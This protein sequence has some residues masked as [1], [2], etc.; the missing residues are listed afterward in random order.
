MDNSISKFN[1]NDSS[2]IDINANSNNSL[3]PSILGTS[4]SLS[5]Q[6]PISQYERNL[7]NAIQPLAATASTVDERGIFRVDAAGKLTIDFLA[8][9]G[10]YH[11]QMAIFSL[12][13]MENLAVG[14]TDFV[15][16]AINRA[17]SSSNLGYVVINDDGEGARFSG[18]LGES[19]KNDGKYSGIK[20]FNFNP[21]DRVAMMIVP[22]G[23][24]RGISNS[25]FLVDNQ[26][27]LFSIASANPNKAVQLGQLLPNT[28]GWEDLRLDKGGDADYNDIVFQVKGLTG[29]VVD[30]SKVV[31]P[32]KDWQ[33]TIL[34]KEIFYAVFQDDNLPDLKGSLSTDTG[35]S[36]SD[37]ITTNPEILGNLNDDG[38][39]RRFRA[40]LNGGESIDVLSLLQPDNSFV[41]GRQELSLIKGSDLADGNY[42]LVL[43]AEDKFGKVSRSNVE[44]VLDTKAA[45]VPTEVKLKNSSGN[46]T[47]LKTPTLTGKAEAGTLVQVFDGI[48]KLG[49]ILAVDGTWEV[50]TS[51]LTAGVK[52]LTIKAIDLAGNISVSTP[53]SFTIIN[54]II[55]PA[56][57]TNIKIKDDGDTITNLQTPTLVGK[58]ETGNTVQIFDGLTKLGE[59]I[60]A[61]GL[62]AITTSQL[63]N[64]LKNLIVKSID[65]N[66]NV[67]D[68]TAF[69]LTVDSI[70]P[71]APTEI[72]IKD[73]TDTVTALK[74]PTLIGKAEAGTVVQVFDG[75]TKIGEATVVNGAWEITTSS[76]TDGVK[77]LT[78]K[79]IDLAGNASD[80]TAFSLTVDSIK[81]VAPTEVKIKDDTDAV[82]ALKTPTLIGKAETGTVVQVFDGTTK[83]GEAT[84]VNGAWEITTSSLT[85]GVKNLTVKSIDVAGNISDDTAF[86][87]TVDTKIPK[88]AAP[89]ELKIKNDLDTITSLKVPTLTGK[90]ENGTTVQVFDGT[91]KIGEATVVN[92]AWEITTSPLTDGV[93]NL[94]VKSI[95]SKGN[96]SDNTAFSLT[97]DTLLPTVSLT[98]PGANGQLVAGSRL[99][100]SVDGTGSAISAVSYR[101]GAGAEI[102]VPI[103]AGQFDVALNLAGLSGAQ[104]LILR[105]VDVAGNTTEATI[106]VTVAVVKDTTPPKVVVASRPSTAVNFVELTFDEPVTDESFAADKYS[107]KIS[108]GVQDGQVVPIGSVQKLSPTQVRVNLATA[109]ATGSY[110]LALAAG[111]TDV[112]GNATTAAQSFDLIVASAAVKISPASGEEKVN[113]NRDTIV[114]FGKK[115]DPATVT[116]DNFYLIANGQRVAGKIKVSSTEEFA[117]FIYD[118]SLPSSTEIRVTVNGD[119]IIGRDGLAIDGNGDGTPGGMA[120]GDFSTLPITQIPGTEVYG[121]VYDSYNKN[122]DGSNI[123]LKGVTIRLDSLPNVTATTDEKGYFILKDLPA[124]DFFVYI[125]GAKASGLPTVSSY[126]GLGKAFHSVPGQSVQLNANGTA[127]NIYLPPMAASDVQ[128]LSATADTNVGFGAAAQKFLQDTFPTIDPELWKDVKVTFNAGSAQDK[129]GVKATQ[130]TIIPVAPDRLP[131]PLPSGVD[132]KL[133]ISIQAGGANGFNREVQGGSTTFDVPAPIQFPNLEGLKPGEKSLFW[134]FDHDAGKWVVIGTGTVSADGRMVVSDP[135]VGVLS[136]GWHFAS[137]GTT[138]GG[139]KTFLK[140][141]G[142]GPKY[143]PKPPVKQGDLSAGNGDLD[144]NA[145][146]PDKDDDDKFDEIEIQLTTFIPSEI[147]AITDLAAIKY[148]ATGGAIGGAVA[149]A[150]IGA[151]TIGALGAFFGALAGPA[152]AVDVG[153]LGG[154]IG[155]IGGATVGV[156][157]GATVGAIVGYIAAQP[158]YNG[159]NRGFKYVS[160]KSEDYKGFS[161]IEIDLNSPNHPKIL[162]DWSQSKQY[163]RGDAQPVVGKLPWWW[164]L[165]TPGIQPVYAPP[166]LEVNDNNLKV[167]ALRPSLSRDSIVQDINFHVSGE[168]KAFQQPVIDQI[169][170]AAKIDANLTVSISQTKGSKPQY[171]ISGTHDGFPAYELYIN[172]KLVYSYLPNTDDGPF[173][174]GLP[175]GKSNV[176]I[177]LNEQKVSVTRRNID[178]PATIQP[179][180]LFVT[181]V[182]QSEL[183]SSDLSLNLENTNQL[184]SSLIQDRIIYA[185]V[186]S[187]SGEVRQRG[188]STNGNIPN[189]IVLASNSLNELLV[190][191]PKTNAFGFAAILTGDNGTNLKLDNQ[192]ILDNLDRVDSDGDGLGDGAELVLG[193]NSTQID[194]DK[195]GISDFT[196]FEQGLDPLGDRGFPTGIISSLPLQGEAKAIVIEGST[197]N[198]TQTAYVATGS[199][200][201]AVVNTSQFNEPIILGQLNLAGDATDVAV[202]T[203]LNIAAVAANSGGLHLVNVAD[204]MLPTLRQSVNINSSQVEIADGIAYATVNN[205]LHSIDLS[206][207]QELQSLTLIGIGSVTGLV[208]EG[209]KLYAFTNGSNTFSIIDIS[210]EGSAQLLGQLNV[211]NLGNVGLSVGNGVA[212]LSS[213]GLTTIDV[214]DPTK[215][216]LISGV[217]TRF[218]S[219]NVTLNG[220]GLAL[221]TGGQGLELYSTVD[222][223]KTDNFVTRINTPSVA[224]GTAIAS[225][226]AY[227]A[228]GTSGL[229]IINYLPF[230]NKGIAPIINL[231]S[232]VTDLDPNVDGIQVQEGS[233]IPLQI[234]IT[235]DVQ[236]RNVELLVDG[237]VVSNDVSFPWDLSVV[238]PAIAPGKDTVGIQVRA[239]DTGGNIALSNLLT[240]NL[241]TDKFAPTVIG[242]TPTA[243][244]RSKVIPTVAIK[245]NEAIDPT[246][247]NVSGITLTNLGADG[248]LGGG[249][250]VIATVSSLQTRNFDKTLVIQPAGE[251]SVGNYQLSVDP[252]II[253][254]RVGNVIAAPITTSFTKRPLTTNVTI[255]E[256]IVGKLVQP[257]DDE[258]YTFNGTAGQRLILDDKLL[259]SN[260][261]A[262]LTNPSGRLLNSDGPIFTASP[263]LTLTE[264]GKYKFT[265]KSSSNANA[266]GDYYF[267][268]LDANTAP[269]ITLGVT[270]TE[271]LSAGLDTNVYRIDGV[272]GQKL[273]FNSSVPSINGA[274]WQLYGTA[275]QQLTQNFFVNDFEAVLPNDGTY[276]LALSRKANNPT[277]INYS[278]TVTSPPVTTA[279]LTLGTTITD[280][281]TQPGETKEYTFV[282]TAGQ[283]LY[284][285]GLISNNSSSISSQLINP[286]G[287]DIFQDIFS[288]SDADRDRGLLTLTESGTY[289]LV[290][291]G[292]LDNVGD[293]SFKLIDANVSPVITLGET[294]T[295]VLAPGLET[296]IY[297]I[298]GTA[299]QQ[300]YIDSLLNN[301]NGSWALYGQNNQFV[302][303][304]NGLNNDFEPVLPTDGTYLLVINGQNTNGNSNYSFKVTSPVTTTNALNLGTTVTGT[305]SKVGEKNIYTFT[306]LPGQKLFYD[307]VGSNVNTAIY[308]QLISPNGNIVFDNKSSDRDQSAFTLT[309]AGT[310]QIIID[311]LG[312]TIGDYSFRLLDISTATPLELGTT[313]TSTLT[314]GLKS[315]FYQIRGIAGQ[316]LYFDS[317]VNG[318]N[319]SWSLY[320][321]NDQYVSGASLNNDFEAILTDTGNYLLQINGQNANGNVNYS[322]KV[323][324]VTATSTVLTLGDTVASKIS[325]AGEQDIYTFTGTAGQRIYYDALTNTTALITA[326]LFS[327]SG[328]IF[329]AGSQSI[330]DNIDAD[331]DRRPITLTESGT[332][333]LVLDGSADSTGDYSFRLVDVS[334]AAILSLNTPTSGTLNP[335][336]KTEVYQ[337]NG[338]AGQKL[339]FDSLLTGAVNGSWALYNSNNQYLI[340]TGLASDFNT[341]LPNDGTY[342]LL[343][344]GSSIFGGNSNGTVNYN[345][346]VTDVSDVPVSK[347]GFNILYTGTITTGGQDTYTLA[348]N[349]GTFVYFDSQ[350]PGANGLVVEVKDAN[351]QSVTSF[352]ANTDTQPLRLNTS[353]NHTV[354]VKGASPTSIGSYSFQ[355]IDITTAATDLTL[356]TPVTKVLANGAETVVYKFSGAAG[357]NLYY[358]GLQND[359]DMVGTRLITPSGTILLNTNSDFDTNLTTLT[360]SGTYYLLISGN[361]STA[362][363]YSFNLIDATAA[364]TLTLDAVVTDKLEPGLETNIYRFSGVAGQRLYFNSLMTAANASWTLYGGTNNQLL[365]IELLNSDFET[366]LTN[367]GNYFLVLRGSNATGNIDYSF[368]VTNLASNITALTLGATITDTITQPG[369][370]K[371]YT[372]AGTAGQILYYDGLINNTSIINSRLFS[373]SGKSAFPNSSFFSNLDADSDQAPFVLTESGNYKLTIDGNLD[374][375]GDFSFKL[376]DTS[377]APLITFDQIVSESLTPSLEADIYRINVTAEEILYFDSLL[378]TTNAFWSLYRLDSR[379]NNGGFGFGGNVLSTDF[380]T[381]LTTSGTYLLVINGQN[382]TDNIKYSFKVT[383]PTS[384]TTAVTLGTTVTGTI[385]QPG[386]KDIYTFTGTTGQQLL[387]DELVSNRNSDITAQLISPSGQNIVYN[388]NNSDVDLPFTLTESGNYQII[389]DGRAADIGD[390]AFRLIDLSTAPPVTIGTTIT[391]TLTPGLESD[392]YQI[393]AKAGERLYFDSLQKSTGAIWTLYKPNGQV[394]NVVDL[395]SDLETTTLDANGT[396]YLVIRG[397]TANGNVNYSFKV[398]N[399]PTSSTPLTLGTTI[400][401]TI[402]EVGEVDEYTFTAAVGQQLYYDGLGGTATGINSQIIGPS[403][404]APIFNGAVES[405]RRPVTITETGVYRLI[406]DGSGGNIG[407][408]NFRLLNTS[409]APVI[410]LNTTITNTLDPGLKT[411][412]Y[413]ISGKAGQKL[414]F[415]SLVTGSVIG[416]WS[417][418]NSNYGYINGNSFNLS[419]D[420]EVTLN[421]DGIYLLFINGDNPNGTVNYKFRVIE[422]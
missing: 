54:E 24:I 68:D 125:D 236:V 274:S 56:A 97:V 95:D 360:E 224:Y 382:R 336:L 190:W 245:F 305:I 208:R 151:T 63:I 115:V 390:Y 327:P 37:R 114:N 210:T 380:E 387:Y 341:T 50:T 334:T 112:A 29:S 291:D 55:K 9:S 278:F 120:T 138:F 140:G 14:S 308:A 297:R 152:G 159:N 372:F 378:N 227:V 420:F 93:K 77:N 332:Y 260:F 417:L 371:E 273:L 320:G 174:L 304:G 225:G 256:S 126:A 87:L 223:Q 71:V 384:V 181:E 374:S 315:D 146:T 80:D 299:G 89:T 357:Q 7:I 226:I 349:A 203:N 76:L 340:G 60:V 293:Y 92:G 136:P 330:F 82:T 88:P 170:Q 13:G 409:N 191:Q 379:S 44:F 188:I 414:R 243:D 108:G 217:D 72:K 129:E 218:P 164:E 133:V 381:T 262:D 143:Q 211:G 214:S 404:Q 158:V 247:L 127:F 396:Y 51:E 307:A 122:A 250:D 186:D 335:G 362:A 52:D 406:I 106:A 415:D 205:V 48:K 18:E 290:I 172:K 312:S 144:Q 131:A 359:A 365:A 269:A 32:G 348:A 17:L 201:L 196:E 311:G 394:S 70:K 154:A 249:D 116:G 233:T 321:L 207:G 198:N 30:V 367:N 209:T 416:K 42:K 204:G 313:V 368:N 96:A 285:D 64:G 5:Q 185:I 292:Q 81:P 339:K 322:F 101:F 246:K 282:G 258:V 252:S 135:G 183:A 418:Y 179:N 103:T 22:Q 43:E 337:I 255:G 148:G 405:D 399:P 345:F 391:D 412:V 73:D 318:A 49:E 69:S 276:L 407:D 280:T 333:K 117:T 26:L 385:A 242:T 113:L 61:N 353:G 175:V 34:A 193:T 85:D 180:S 189:N 134:S 271:T 178:K 275:N 20:T 251:L 342:L 296:D 177:P 33:E 264:A 84:A 272:A 326:Q 410:N 266:I 369:E 323:T 395:S 377:T 411:D 197:T 62:W 392:V 350:S 91:T 128:Q 15:K 194:T 222:P 169:L 118:A 165:K 45:S 228:N 241:S 67:S 265:I 163:N 221:V 239:T 356:G 267:R 331:L 107:L 422:I 79:S 35:T 400:K 398:T 346:Q 329:S 86:S 100:G 347:S 319:V 343:L 74:T 202:D 401:G 338:V 270:V 105:L 199:Y 234:N 41:F 39:I 65:A 130:A 58:A 259:V 3:L 376:V 248:V 38:G 344:S 351:N 240:L 119:K 110:K 284:Y 150:A 215:P 373:P 99:Q 216:K 286:I 397:N 383:K 155:A 36:S 301:I 94:T 6:V 389:I 102:V 176:E 195:D 366:T 147:V 156:I 289:K 402:A 302:T 309:E 419:S 187:L 219:Q 364:P 235:D 124:P 229:Q 254:D 361:N 25:F 294:V 403:K 192:L 237:Q 111:L 253:S 53:F 160:Y 287:Q 363:D 314:P 413:Q 324:D 288:G 393:N 137:Q 303:G 161:N 268:I 325:Q 21:G 28:F 230:D 141:D 90:A 46:S 316:R 213:N 121:Y 47:V 212:Y 11:S 4:S 57:P 157:P 132:P 238:A 354:T 78:A 123:P 257:G 277:A 23:T 19:N 16:E 220:S 31:A 355:A 40:G 232:S 162:L 98:T 200:G 8:D 317:L 375:I 306:G 139:G 370:T 244:S 408:Y 75:T 12:R 388:G 166:E 298:S 109:F 149:G 295:S 263:P 142:N 352:V 153:L 281:I 310:Y 171:S 300:L 231:N 206:N 104:N 59:A 386:E 27:P 168:N 328:Q 83:I 173:G 184:Q 182:S 279:A 66:G 261:R 2:A 358:D 283:R 10:S 1:T 421:G 167:T 145:P